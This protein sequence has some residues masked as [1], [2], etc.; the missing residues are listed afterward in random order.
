MKIE[1]AIHDVSLNDFEFKEIFSNICSYNI[2]NNISVL[3]CHLKLITQLNHPDDILISTPIDYP[4]GILGIQPK[5]SA[6]HDAHHQY[7]NI[8]FIDI[9]APSYYLSSRKYAKFREEIKQVSAACYSLNIIPRY[10]LEYRVFSLPLLNKACEIL[11]N[12]NIG[13]ILPSTGYLL[14]SI[15]DNLTATIMLKKKNPSINI[16]CN[17][18]IWNNNHLNI[19]QKTDIYG[20]RVS[21]FQSLDMILKKI[22]TGGVY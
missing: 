14:D 6:I 3:P 7:K 17:G 9:V 1:Y 16:I 18:N 4:L 19:I 21:S 8:N 13:E 11:Y 10:I 2:V 20:I 22:N 12:H 5:I 15:F